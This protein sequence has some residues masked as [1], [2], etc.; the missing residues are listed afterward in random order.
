MISRIETGA[1]GARFQTVA[2][3]AEALAI[4]PAE[5]FSPDVD[6]SKLLRPKLTAITS[7]LAALSDTDLDWLDRVLVAVLRHR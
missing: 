6:G 3:L 2:K 7:R 4:D 1:S 5:L